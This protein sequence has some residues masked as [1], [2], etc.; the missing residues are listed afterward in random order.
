MHVLLFLGAGASATFGK[1]TTA[2]LKTSLVRKYGSQTRLDFVQSL[3][4]C[5]DFPDIEYVRRGSMAKE[6]KPSSK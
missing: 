2:E 3:V 1:P 5:P 6:D 4:N